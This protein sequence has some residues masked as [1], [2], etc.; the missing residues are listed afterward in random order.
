MADYF[1]CLVRYS[2][3]APR[4]REGFDHGARRALA[5]LPKVISGQETLA[6]LINKIATHDLKLRIRLAKYLL[7]QLSLTIDAKWK[8]LA[9]KAH[10][11]LLQNYADSW[12]PVY[13]EG[14]RRLRVRLR[15][16]MT[17]KTLVAMVSA[18]IAGFAEHAAGTGQQTYLYGEDS[19]T[20]LAEAVQS[21]IYA[22]IDP[23]GG[24]PV[25]QVL[26]D[27]LADSPP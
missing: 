5:E 26:H 13:E 27:V 4:W 25:S 11:Q 2:L 9:N 15:P 24:L 8:D 1:Q 10:R 20:L 18:L 22:A 6:G 14:I 19:A 3:L 16:G 17:T 21:L 12:V 7:F 23:G